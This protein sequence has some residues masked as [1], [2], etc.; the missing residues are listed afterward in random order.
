MGRLRQGGAMVQP[1]SAVVAR[2]AG[3]VDALE[4]FRHD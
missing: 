1:V 3:R 4:S 2:R